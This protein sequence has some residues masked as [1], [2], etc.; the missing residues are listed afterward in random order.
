MR[1]H[2]EFKQLVKIIVVKF[3]DPYAVTI[4]S[5]PAGTLVSGYT[6]TFDYPILSSVTLTC[7][8]ASNN[9]SSFTVTSYQW[10]T[11]GCYSNSKF[12]PS[13]PRCF[14]HGG[15]TQNVTDN[16]IAHDAGTITCT[17]IIS[18]RNYTSE[19][20]TLR[21]SGEQLVYCVIAC[22]VYCKQCMLLLLATCYCCII[23]QLLW[24]MYRGVFTVG[25]AVTRPVS[26][27]DLNSANAIADYS[28]ITAMS[29]TSVNALIA[30]CL[31][32]LGPT[33]TNN[34]ALGGLYFNG[35][36]IPNRG[37]GAGCTT[38]SGVIQVRPGG[39]IAGLTNIHQCQTFNT[40]NEGVYTCA[41][42]NSANFNES[43]RFGIYFTGRSESHDLY[44][45][46][47]NHFSSSYTAVPVIDTT[48][49][50]T[51]TVNFGSSLTLSCTS[52]GSPPDTFTWR[53]DNDPTVLQSTN[54]TAVDYTS[55]SAVF[56]ANYSIDSVTSSDSG[57]YSCT[58]T[59]P[60]GSN[61]ATITVVVSK[62]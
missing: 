7:N 31:T 34:G 54:I 33:G 19:P 58:V 25:V 15:T 39:G 29:G 46:S 11:D 40:D 49:S 28:F 62:L 59:N 2:I 6:N 47:L 43:V 20:F 57:T 50:S 38:A 24:F 14:P 35:T 16:V 32:G 61:S 12:T 45:P 53:K 4:V 36:M 9:G 23:H 37:E 18:G 13:N 42:K 26:N 5:S 56:L 52:Q 30:R 1:V 41:L 10:N 60:I 27:A 17:V 55:A 8:V 48:S 21:I 51:V 44:I 22:I 3:S